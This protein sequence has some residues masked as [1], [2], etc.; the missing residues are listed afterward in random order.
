[1]KMTNMLRWCVV[2]MYLAFLDMN[3]AM[4]PGKETR[5]TA[6]D[7]F[8]NQAMTFRSHSINESNSV[9]RLLSNETF[10]AE[11]GQRKKCIVVVNDR[12]KGFLNWSQ[13]WFKAAAQKQCNKEVILTERKTDNVKA[14]VIVFHAPTHKIRSGTTARKANA[15]P[16]AILAMVSMEQPKYSPVLGSLK[17]LENNMDLMVTYS[18]KDIYPGT[19]LPNMPITYYPL[20]IVSAQ[21]IMQPARPYS[22][23]TGYGTGVDVALF[24]SNCMN[25]GA[26]ARSAYIEELMKHVK[27]HSYG[28]CFKN[29]EEPKM[30]EDPRWPQ[31]AQRRARK[32]KVLS[33]YKFYLA[34]EN[35]AFDDYVSEKVFEGLIAGALT[36]YRGASTIHRFM[37]SNDSFI[38][39][40]AMSPKELGALINKIAKDEVLYNSYFQFKSRP[41]SSEFEHMA[42]MSY[43]HPNVLCRLC[44]YV[45]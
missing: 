21:A 1:M 16:D 13:D 11:S 23:K 12:I 36:V 19:T 7:R 42:L 40:N 10:A 32:I 44:N 22:D 35:A 5:T 4:F 9:V 24:T 37:P 39:A 38:D 34:F 29:R 3:D 31:I 27:V 2:L 15:N 45:P 6:T 41:M 43:I 25:A 17:Y 30:A 8:S 26:K 20:H 28:K 18:L 33:N 14:D